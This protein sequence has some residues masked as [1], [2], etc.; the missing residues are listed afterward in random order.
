[1]QRGWWLLAA[2]PK[3]ATQFARRRVAILG[4]VTNIPCEPRL[5]ANKLGG[6]ERYNMSDEVHYIQGRFL[7]NL[8]PFQ[9]LF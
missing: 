3:G 6:S 7:I 8:Y 9:G 4:K 5:T 1:M 2:R